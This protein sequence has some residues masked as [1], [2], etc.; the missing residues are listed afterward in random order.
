MCNTVDKLVLGNYV[1]SEVHTLPIFRWEYIGST[2]HVCD[3]NPRQGEGSSVHG[4]K[5]RSAFL[6][7]TIPGQDH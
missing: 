2:L 4:N 7:M 1:V 5:L 3:W 6:W